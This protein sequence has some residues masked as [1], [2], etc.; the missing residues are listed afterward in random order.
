MHRSHEAL[1][2]AL[3]RVT[4]EIEAMGQEWTPT[5]IEYFTNFLR[6]WLVDHVIKED[7]LMKP[8]LKKY[9]PNFNPK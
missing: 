7:L 4:Q 8:T 9:P 2:K 5:A 1:V 3:E 6:N